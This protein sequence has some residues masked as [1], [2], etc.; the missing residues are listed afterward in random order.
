MIDRN[1][2][3]AD[4]S[5]MAADS[6]RNYRRQFRTE[7]RQSRRRVMELFQDSEPEGLKAATRRAC[8]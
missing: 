2:I 6:G 3:H 7:S 1:G 5:G 4:S 8:P